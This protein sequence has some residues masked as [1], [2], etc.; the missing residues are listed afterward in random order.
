[1][2]MTSWRCRAISRDAP[3]QANSAIKLAP[4]AAV[5]APFLNRSRST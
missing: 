3:T 1:M 2:P 5:N 4:S